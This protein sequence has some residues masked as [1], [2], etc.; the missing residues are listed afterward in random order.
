MDSLEFEATNAIATLLYPI[1][2][3]SGNN[4][5]IFKISGIS[6]NAPL[7]YLNKGSGMEV[8]GL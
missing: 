1:V 2:A 5:A 4:N 7:R 8:E 3:N 6:I